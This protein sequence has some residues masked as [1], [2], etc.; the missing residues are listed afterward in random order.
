MTIIDFKMTTI[1]YKRGF[2]AA[3]KMLNKWC[4]DNPDL[5]I[6]ELSHMINAGLML[7]DLV[8]E[9]EMKDIKS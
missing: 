4:E 8:N 6:E 5:T 3:M 9:A 2:K 7:D 1:E